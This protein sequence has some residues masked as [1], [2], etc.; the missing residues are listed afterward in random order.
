MEIVIIAVVAVVLGGL[1]YINH[2]KK[3]L[4]KNNDGKVD[5]Q[6]VKAAVKEVKEEVKAVAKKTTTKAKAVVA[7][8][9]K[10]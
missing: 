5:V 2:N 9:T 3:K 4:D 6:E 8:K 1:I 7:K 10:K